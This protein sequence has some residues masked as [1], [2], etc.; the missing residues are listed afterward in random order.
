MNVLRWLEERLERDWTHCRGGTNKPLTPKIVPFALNLEHVGN[1]VSGYVERRDFARSLVFG[2]KAI[3]AVFVFSLALGLLGAMLGAPGLRP[4][5]VLVCVLGSILTAYF[6]FVIQHFRSRHRELVFGPK[7]NALT[8]QTISSEGLLLSDAHAPLS[9]CSVRIHRVQL[10]T[11]RGL[12]WS[13]WS[14]V[15]RVSDRSMALACL[16]DRREI[17]DYVL[18]MPEWLKSVYKGEGEPMQGLMT[19][20]WIGR[21]RERKS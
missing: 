12:S 7:Q 6:Y 14:V 3:L 15:V 13:G 18:G 1:D 8:I 17:D 11:R 16:K 2:G 10:C 4:R 21:A 9:E 19:D 5:L 20:V